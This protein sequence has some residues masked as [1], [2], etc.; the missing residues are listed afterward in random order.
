MTSTTI[1]W[2]KQNARNARAKR[3]SAEALEIPAV[4]A[5]PLKLRNEPEEYYHVSKRDPKV[6]LPKLKFLERD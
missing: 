1:N 2:H 3:G 5:P 6:S 4:Y